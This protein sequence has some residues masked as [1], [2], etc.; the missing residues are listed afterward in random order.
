MSLVGYQIAP[1]GVGYQIALLCSVGL[2]TGGRKKKIEY[3]SL[4]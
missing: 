3:K 1:Q 4:L 2:K